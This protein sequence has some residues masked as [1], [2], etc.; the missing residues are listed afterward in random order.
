MPSLESL[1][2]I[3]PEHVLREQEKQEHPSL[4]FFRTLI[5]VL[6]L[7][8]VLPKLK[9]LQLADIETNLGQ[10]LVLHSRNK[11]APKVFTLTNIWLV[12]T[13]GYN[14][15]PALKAKVNRDVIE[16]VGVWDAL[17]GLR[18]ETKGEGEERPEKCGTL[19]RGRGKSDIIGSSGEPGRA[20]LSSRF[21]YD[22]AA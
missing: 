1:I 16:K 15:L 19:T 11:R 10:V 20:K 7:R 17:Y 14:L 21:F 4:E 6:P 18:P 13:S 2:T 8:H 3:F 12:D 5:D 9:T 22:N